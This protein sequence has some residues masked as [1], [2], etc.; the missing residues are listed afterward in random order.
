[1]YPNNANPS[2]ERHYAT[3]GPVYQQG[4]PMQQPTQINSPYQYGMPQ[5]QYGPYSQ[6]QPY[7]GQHANYSGQ[8]IQNI[9]M[10]N[11]MGQEPRTHV[12]LLAQ[13]QAFI[14]DD[15]ER[16]PNRVK[17]RHPREIR[18]A[19]CQRRGRTATKHVIGAGT[20]TIGLALFCCGCWP[21]ACVPCCLEDC[22]DV[23]HNCSNCGAE[24]G[25][26][27]YLFDD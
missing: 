24:C 6:G 27:R 15:E 10:T 21:C 25:T 13:P 4:I 14:V 19:V 9:H 7:Y 11:V 23:Q 22:M 20:W 1:M 17:S 26:S 8:P 12:V 16:L 3:G 5:N 2:G 18:C